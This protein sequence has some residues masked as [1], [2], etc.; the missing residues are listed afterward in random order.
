MTLW[1]S[2]FNCKIAC[3]QFSSLPDP[4]TI[5]LPGQNTKKFPQ[6][7]IFLSFFSPLRFAS[8]QRNVAAGWKHER[9]LTKRTNITC[10][11]GVSLFAVFFLLFDAQMF[12][13]SLITSSFGG[14]CRSALIF[15]LFLPEL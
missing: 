8:Q 4:F 15:R 11:D 7:S 6:L 5:F 2:H 9:Q 12:E 1:G 3:H 14:R 10:F 13:I